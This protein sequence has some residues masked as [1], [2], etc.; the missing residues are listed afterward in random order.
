VLEQTYADSLPSTPIYFILSP[1]ADIV[2]NLDQLAASHGLEKGVSY[3]NVS[4]GQGQDRTAENKL[5]AAHKQGHWVILNNVHLMPRWLAKLEKMLDDFALDNG[6]KGSH[7]NFRLFL[8]SDP[9]DAI[10]VGILNRS[11]KLTNEPPTG[12]KANLKRAFCSFKP[13]YINEIDSKQR[14]ILFGLCYFHAI[15]VE[16]KK[17][18]PKGYNMMYPFSLGDLRDSAICLQNYMENASSKIPWEDLRYIFGQ[19]M[20]GGHIVND[21]DRLLCV[22]YLDHI[23]RDELLDEMEL[24][25]F[26]KD[27]GVSF[28]S[29]SPTTY[30]RYLEHIEE[31]LRGDTPIAFGL[32]PNAEIGY[33][34]TQSETLFNLLLEL[35]PR[36][37]GAG[38]DSKDPREEAHEQLKELLMQFGDVN[39][40]VEDIGTSMD[41]SGGRG[42]FQNVLLLELEQMMRLINEIKRSLEELELGF[43]GRLTMSDAMDQLELAL[44]LKRVP[45]RWG[46]LAWPSLR[47]LPDWRNDLQRRIFQLND[48]SSNPGEILRVTWLSGLINPQSFLTAIQ[49]QQAQAEHD[50]LDRLIIQTE[51]TKKSAD[52]IDTASRDGAFI[53]GLFLQ[54]A[55]WDVATGV[56]E[57][58]KPREMN[59]LLPVI[60]ARS[61]P[62]D[63][64][65][66]KGIYSCP[67]YKSEQRGPTY[68][69]SAQLKTKSPPARWI[70]GG[71]AVILDVGV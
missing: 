49:Q 1:G 58:S 28:M 61:I 12:L 27:E 25:P 59:C 46:K 65:E 2:S 16:R 3:H 38:G 57:K 9:S 60:N 44:V 21:F 35:Q 53:T 20:Y 33:R 55:R 29:P 54:G 48:W 24:F 23:M 13:E 14:A 51:V 64:A 22:T 45:V 8:T 18:G 11:I 26:S 41:E 69:F 34:L 39:Y 32:H 47:T 31:S 56:L 30:E 52:E 70:M 6:G 43:A 50:E 67:V 63:K 68:V 19:I 66:T 42:P 36:G 5:L 17:F 40:E 10:P 37:A 4:M 62:A 71:V 7:E 15:T